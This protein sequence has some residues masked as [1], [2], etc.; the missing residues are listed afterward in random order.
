G[1]AAPWWFRGPAAHVAPDKIAVRCGS[2]A[3]HP[4]RHA[5]M[6]TFRQ[7]RRNIHVYIDI[8]GTAAAKKT[9]SCSIPQAARGCPTVNGLCAVGL[10][11]QRQKLA[12]HGLVAG[13]DLALGEQ[14]VAAVEIAGESAGLAHDDQ[15][16]RDVPGRQVALPVGVEPAGRHP[17]EI[18]RGGTEPA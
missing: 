13:E 6:R 4:L 7:N 16:A 12:L 14:L 2:Y 8:Y 9:R 18:E 10:P 11:D 5:A 15:P 17:G 1:R 3:R